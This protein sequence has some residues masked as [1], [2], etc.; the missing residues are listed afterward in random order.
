MQRYD[1][2]TDSCQGYTSALRARAYALPLRGALDKVRFVSFSGITL[3]RE[4]FSL[5]F[6]AK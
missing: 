4:K 6:W 5:L 3:L 1:T 2:N